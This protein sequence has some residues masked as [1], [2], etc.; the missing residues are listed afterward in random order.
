ML[1][2]VPSRFNIFE[3]A[4]AVEVFGL[5]RRALTP[6]WY[7]FEMVG[8]SRRVVSNHGVALSGVQGSIA[9]APP[10]PW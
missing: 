5:D 7:R 9:C 4:V 1:A 3:L 6:D 10:T 2:L 8:E